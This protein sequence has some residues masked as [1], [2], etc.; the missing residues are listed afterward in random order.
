MNKEL[1][2]GN[3]SYYILTKPSSENVPLYWTGTH[4][5]VS[6]QN[7]K[8]FEKTS[9]IDSQQVKEKM[10]WLLVDTIV[11]ISKVEGL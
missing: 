5:S 2:I 6:F 4:W 11:K 3:H 8:R 10:G 9:F 1:L 7:A